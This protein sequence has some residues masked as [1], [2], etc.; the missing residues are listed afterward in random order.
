MFF[1]GEKKNKN[2]MEGS[3]WVSVWEEMYARL[4]DSRS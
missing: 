3:V 2:L 1:Y 4:D